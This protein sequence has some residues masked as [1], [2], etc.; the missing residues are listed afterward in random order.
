[1]PFLI[2]SLESVDSDGDG[3]GDN[4]DEFP[5]NP[6]EWED[7]DF[8]GLGDN[9]EDISLGDKDNDGVVDSEDALW[10]TLMS[11]QMQTEMV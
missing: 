8:D 11:G 1:M 4:L 7:L 6:N 10:M 2:D 5:N 9:E 3:Y